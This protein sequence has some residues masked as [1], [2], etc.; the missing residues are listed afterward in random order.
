MSD[1]IS[2]LATRHT[3]KKFDPT[4][5]IPEA[6]IA[7]V[8]QILQLS[9]S[10]TNSQPWHFVIAGTEEGKERIARSAHGFYEFN[11]PKI[12]NASHVVVLCT[13]TDI[14]T[15]YTDAI[16]E[17]E[18][19][20]GRFPSDEVMAMNKKGREYFTNLHRTELKDVRHWMEKQTFI[21]LGNL[22]IGAAHLGLHACPMEGFD[23][24]VL[25]RELGLSDKGFYPSVIVSLGYGAADDFNAITPKSRWPLGT[26]I[27][28]I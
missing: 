15:A 3:T 20:D 1:Y 7:A 11:A 21:A 19:I 17:Q 2:L 26:I 12:R 14:D 8:K 18:R 5:R 9:P 24:E 25:N 4:R 13:K 28:E 10:S 27:T 16:V 6:T 22:L 23:Y